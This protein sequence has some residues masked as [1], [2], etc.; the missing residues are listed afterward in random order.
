MRY[1]PFQLPIWQAQTIL[2][3]P[4][5]PAPARAIAANNE[6]LGGLPPVEEPAVLSLADFQCKEK[7]GGLRKRYT[8]E[9]VF[10]YDDLGGWPYGHQ[11]FV[12]RSGTVALEIGEG[13]KRG[14]WGRLPD[15]SCLSGTSGPRRACQEF[16]YRNCREFPTIYQ[17]RSSL[18]FKD[19][20]QFA[21]SQVRVS[22]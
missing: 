15:L 13:R 16:P 3:P 11:H 19:T 18:L 4:A 12:A 2:Q 8:V 9:A 17:T 21:D 5:F 20:T 7:L 22:T 14:S 10:V 6:P 1:R